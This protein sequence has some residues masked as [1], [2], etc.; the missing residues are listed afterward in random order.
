MEPIKIAPGIIKDR[1]WIPNQKEILQSQMLEVQ[2]IP[3]GRFWIYKVQKNKIL[4][5]NLLGVDIGEFCKN[6]IDTIEDF[7][8]AI[9][10]FLRKKSKFNYLIDLK[11]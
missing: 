8:A 1:L 9:G 6:N 2:Y 11:E 7:D 4:R 3:S 10:N 5:D